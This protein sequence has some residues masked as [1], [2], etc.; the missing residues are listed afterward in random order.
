MNTVLGYAGS[1]PVH[2]DLVRLVDTRM[3]VQA[4]SGGGKSWL[5]RLIAERAAGKVQT[6]I[7]DPEGEFSTLREKVDMLLVGDGGEVA[8]DVRS[9]KLLAR[10]LIELR[11]SAVVDLYDLKLSDRR[12]YV[13]L[14][15]ESLMAVPRKHW[16]Q[17]IVMIDESHVFAPERSAGDAESTQAVISLMSQGRKRGFCGI[18]ATQRI[19]KLHKD[20]AAECNNVC[21][22]RTN[23]DVDLK[24]AADVLGMSKADAA[25]L[26]TL[27]PG[28]WHGFGPAFDFGGVE[29]FKAA[30][31]ATKHPEAGKRHEFTAPAPSKAISKVLPELEDLPA[32]AEKEIDDLA[33]AKAKIAELERHAK[34]GIQPV[35]PEQIGHAE[36]RG[37]E[38]ALAELS[39]DMES[40]SATCH[41]GY[42][43][44]RESLESI[45]K[46]VETALT[47]ELPLK[48]N[49]VS[50]VPFAGPRADVVVKAQSVTAQPKASHRVGT[51]IQ[52]RLPKAERNILAAVGPFPQGR[53]KVQIALLCGYSHKG[54]GFNNALGALRSKG[55]IEGYDPIFATDEAH[56]MFGPF[57]QMPKG[58]ALLD[59][60]L[61]HSALGRAERNILETLFQ[62]APR[63]L[64]KEAVAEL[65]GY[66]AAGGGF[67]N[68]LGRLRTLE[69]ITRGK[70][71]TVN[72]DLIEG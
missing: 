42:R 53:S 49:I 57:P 12:R 59:R 64:T 1:K 62:T 11:I 46:I 22:G 38:K 32:E 15:L 55:L 30:S 67:N 50:S 52:G 7:L 68:A 23:L 14:F 40:F 43:A 21:I 60:W 63:K 2:I 16:H 24:R 6:I 48:P 18:L 39:K 28:S 56:R 35:D 4:N 51:T 33:A 10:K 17:V 29:T 34:V 44:F 66:E 37:Y 20:A 5:I 45:A 41:S 3:L 36:R 58:R 27:P 69:L 65:A 8:A 19:S 54:G 26:R 31:V 9:A 71:F 25:K 72:P 13:R 70:E 47:I 61:S